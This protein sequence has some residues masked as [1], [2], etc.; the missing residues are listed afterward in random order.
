MINLQKK[1][2]KK[3]ISNNQKESN[4]LKDLMQDEKFVQEILSTKCGADIIKKFDSQGVD[5][6]KIKF[7]DLCSILAQ[8][9]NLDDSIEVS[10]MDSPW[11]VD[12][13]ISEKKTKV[14]FE[15]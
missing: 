1:E 4:I 13:H 15:D 11:P 2:N 6:N 14:I 7:K 3:E 5:L 12:Y 9:L 8:K 10:S